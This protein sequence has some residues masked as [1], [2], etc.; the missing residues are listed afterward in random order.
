MNNK[1]KNKRRLKETKE[2][3]DIV[4]NEHLRPISMDDFVMKGYGYL[5]IMD[6]VIF[7][8]N[9][10]IEYV[11][12]LGYPTESLCRLRELDEYIESTGH[13]SMMVAQRYSEHRRKICTDFFIS[14]RLIKK[15][16]EIYDVD[17]VREIPENERENFWNLVKLL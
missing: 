9:S 11:D 6:E 2:F 1:R 13:E 16:M 12:L 3:L 10:I 5:D 4:A 8:D 15:A 17:D 7:A 14:I